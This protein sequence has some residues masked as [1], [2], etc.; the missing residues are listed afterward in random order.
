LE[1]LGG[2]IYQIERKEAKNRS[3]CVFVVLLPVQ[4]MKGS[5]SMRRD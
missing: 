2:E 4:R 5:L 1:R 3:K